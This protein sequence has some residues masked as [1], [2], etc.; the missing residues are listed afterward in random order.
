MKVYADTSFLVKLLGSEERSEGAV[1]EFQRL[2]RP[3]LPFLRLHWLET[4]TAFRQRAFHARRSGS[5]KERAG[6]ARIRDASLARVDRWVARG[7][8]VEKTLDWDGAMELACEL[9]ARHVDRSGGRSFDLLQVAYAIQLKSE[10]FVTTDR[11]QREIARAEGLE[12]P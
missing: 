2:N 1:A 12:V 8:L 4:T 11:T 10:M 5:V 6:A 7:W 9:S 3:R